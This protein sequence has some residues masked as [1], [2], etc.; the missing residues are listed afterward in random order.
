MLFVSMWIFFTTE[1]QRA[2]RNTE[3]FQP[4]TSVALCDLR[5]SVVN[6]TEIDKP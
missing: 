3:F 2:Q 5:V 4:N 1:A 6:L